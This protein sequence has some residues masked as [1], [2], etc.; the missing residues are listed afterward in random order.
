FRETRRREGRRVMS[1]RADRV[2]HLLQREI[3]ELLRG[4]KDPRVQQATLV[5]VTHVRVSDD[6]STA[7]VLL[8]I[9]DPE[10]TQVL[11]AVGRAQR[12]L[13]AQLLRRLRAK[14]IPELRFYLD[15]TEERAGRIDALLRDVAAEPPV[16]AS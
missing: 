6:L 16:G 2:A 7:R 14:K 9:I 3:A 1:E 15:D 12:F 5:T 10:P 13:Q 4:L 8:S 11:R